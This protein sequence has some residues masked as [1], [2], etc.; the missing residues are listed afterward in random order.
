MGVKGLWQLLEPAGRRINIEALQN[1]KLAVGAPLLLY[2]HMP[3]QLPPAA[4]ILRSPSL[5]CVSQLIS[6]QTFHR[7]RPRRCL[8]LAVPVCQGH[9]RRSRRAAARGGGGGLLPPHLQVGRPLSRLELPGACAAQQLIC[10]HEPVARPRILRS[11]GW[12][13]KQ[14]H[15]T[16][17]RDVL[18][19]PLCHP[20]PP[21]RQPVLLHSCPW[22]V[23]AAV[24]PHPASVCV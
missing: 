2:M 7:P 12:K 20:S 13:M 15:Y 18:V 22:R 8:H 11:V 9:A 5:P 6:R 24:P 17:L 3:L 4:P 19:A 16:A 23:Q 14:L 21:H 1:K 10:G